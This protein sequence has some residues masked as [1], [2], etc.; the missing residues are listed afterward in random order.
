MFISEALAQ[1]A[2]AAASP[3]PVGT[4]V[5]LALIFLVFY[6]LLIRPQQKKI[7]QHEYMLTTIKKGD[8]VVTNGGVI[9]KIVKVV[10]EQVIEAEIS[11]GV[12][13]KIQ[14]PTIREILTD[15]VEAKTKSKK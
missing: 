9:A 10:D 1:T 4:L 12:V 6:L 11:S 3:S 5:Q 15:K 13:V 2:D 14:R 8:E 7:K